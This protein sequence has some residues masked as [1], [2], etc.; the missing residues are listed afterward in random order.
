[1]PIPSLYSRRIN[2]LFFVQH[3][4]ELR[5]LTSTRWLLF[6]HL[7]VLLPLYRITQNK[8]LVIQ[9]LLLTYDFHR[10]LQFPVLT[11]LSFTKKRLLRKKYRTKRNFSKKSFLP[12]SRIDK[13]QSNITNKRVL[14][15]DENSPG[16]PLEENSRPFV[17]VYLISL[18]HKK[19]FQKY[20]AEVVAAKLILELY[21]NSFFHPAAEGAV[22]GER[23]SK[24]FIAKLGLLWKMEK[25]NLLEKLE[26]KI[27]F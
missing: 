21:F 14:K 11:N 27:Q 17:Q 7:Q 5:F 13:V 10:F 19:K 2:R 26:W 12:F 16:F 4:S 8:G 20:Y 15:V 6:H 23:L 24:I 1:M 9:K 18:L 3:R 25:I 22:F